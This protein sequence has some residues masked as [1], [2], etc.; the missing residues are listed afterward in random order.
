MSKSKSAFSAFG[1]FRKFYL[2]TKFPLRDT[3]PSD[4][5]VLHAS[6]KLLRP[7]MSEARRASNANPPPRR[8]RVKR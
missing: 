8:P 1:A 3:V 7:A 6:A 2:G 4:L 5:Q